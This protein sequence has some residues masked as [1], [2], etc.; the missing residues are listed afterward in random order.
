MLKHKRARNKISTKR[1]SMQR[2]NRLVLKNV[3]AFIAK[4]RGDKNIKIY[5][6]VNVYIYIV[7]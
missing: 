1:M 6:Y 7:D 5:V 3:T 4:T 2:R